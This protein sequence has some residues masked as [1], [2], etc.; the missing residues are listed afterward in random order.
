M[1]PCFQC[2]LVANDKSAETSRMVRQLE[3]A[4]DISFLPF[5]FFL[6]VVCSDMYLF[7]Y[8]QVP[9]LR[10]IVTICSLG[11][12]MKPSSIQALIL[13]VL[14]TLTSSAQHST[15]STDGSPCGTC[16]QDNE[17]EGIAQRWLN[18]FATG[19]LNTLDSAVTENV[20]R[21]KPSHDFRLTI[22]LDRS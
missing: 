8:C 17:V 14:P 4:E 13:C 22:P 5:S 15:S 12:V 20:R 6:R 7:L 2:D 16:I 9:P 1:C 19:G 18:A 10:C 21:F 11:L 3:G